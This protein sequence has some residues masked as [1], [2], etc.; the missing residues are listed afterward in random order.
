MAESQVVEYSVESN[1]YSRTIRHELLFSVAK[2]RF[3]KPAFSR[4]SEGK[5]VYKLL[6]GNYLKFELYANTHKNYASFKIVMVHINNDGQIDYKDLYEVE[7][8]YDDILN[9]TSDINAPYALAEFIRML[10][11]YHSVAHVEDTNYEM[12]E[13]AQQIVESIKKY[14][15]KKGVSQ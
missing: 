5:L 14:F 9:V 10:P 4:K 11:R 13:D 12:A 8:T 6:L 7:T 2:R 1:H 3:I 15:E